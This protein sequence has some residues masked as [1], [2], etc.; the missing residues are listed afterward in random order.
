M[1]AV[2]LSLG[3]HRAPYDAQADQLAALMFQTETGRHRRDPER[4]E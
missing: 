4:T 2:V 1:T 3:R